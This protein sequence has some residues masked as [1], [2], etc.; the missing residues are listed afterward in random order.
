MRRVNF[1]SS[2]LRLFLSILIFI[3]IMLLLLSIVIYKK[4]EFEMITETKETSQKFLSLTKYSVDNLWKW[5]LPY[6]A[7]LYQD[8][9]ILSNIYDEN[10]TPILEA[11][12]MDKMSRAII[13]NPHIHSIYLF[14]R[15]AGRVYSSLGQVTGINYFYDKDILKFLKNNSISQGFKFIPRKNNFIINST[16]YNDNVLSLIYTKTEDTTLN[17]T[18]EG[19]LVLN[20]KGEQIYGMTRA[21]NSDSNDSLIVINEIGKVVS[22]SDPNMF[23]RDLSSEN[24]VQRV[25]KENKGEGNFTEEIKGQKHLI[26]FVKSEKLNWRFLRITPYEKILAKTNGMRF[27][28]VLFNIV[29]IIMAGIIS[30]WLSKRFYLPIGKLV[31]GVSKRI[32]NYEEKAEKDLSEIDYLSKSFMKILDNVE[33]LKH[34]SNSNMIIM[35]QDFLKSM[36]LT[37]NYSEDINTMLEKLGIKIKSG[38]IRIILFK[39]D[40]YVSE[41][42]CKYNEE[43]QALFRFAIGNIAQELLA[44]YFVC[45]SID[46]GNDSVVII[47]GRDENIDAECDTLINEEV[48]NGII[49][50]IQEY[51]SLYLKSSVSCSVGKSV[52]DFAQLPKAYEQVQDMSC[53][54]LLY[55]QK[56]IIFEDKIPLYEQ[57]EYCYPE[58]IQQLIIENIRLGR[59]NLIQDQVDKFFSRL[60]LLPYS[61]IMMML[62]QLVYVTSNIINHIYNSDKN[63]EQLNFKALKREF[64]KLD[65]LEEI[66]QWLVNIYVEAV[67]KKGELNKTSHKSYVDEVLKVIQKDYSISELTVEELASKVGLSVNYLRAIF[68]EQTGVTLSDYVNNYRYEIARD[69][70]LNT[71]LTISE[72]CEKIGIY[73]ANYFYTLF[74]KHNGQTPSQFRKSM[75]K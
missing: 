74:K 14:N 23:L 61:E 25:L 52:E 20:I 43:S 44:E 65:T 6:S 49:I 37:Q 55:G 12:V 60:K 66:K 71:E 70:L 50:Q 1:K 45:E 16:I 30:I 36:L 5:A 7:E 48:I 34:E 17:G 46:V 57:E 4:Y 9:D 41:Y 21:M 64:E 35:R 54:R 11:V 33:N 27:L 28:I 22:H 53:Y 67:N 15:N 58:E 68:K 29:L 10:P 2:L 18:L 31:E 69:L 26:T 47:C 62:S 32:G 63:S 38:D 40:N 51:V 75:K 39:L 73:N 13:S 3:S 19:A 42:C 8:P 24:Y 72:I 59:L 56:S